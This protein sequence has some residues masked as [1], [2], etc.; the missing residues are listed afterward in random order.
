[1]RIAI[2]ARNDSVQPCDVV[3]ERP[4]L[5]QARINSLREAVSKRLLQN[6]AQATHIS[7]A[8]QS[9]KKMDNLGRMGGIHGSYADQVLPRISL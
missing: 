9:N 5:S 1:M 4:E 2:R 8:C 7:G 3:V 6:L